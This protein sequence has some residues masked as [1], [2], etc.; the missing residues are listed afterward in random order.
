MPK[1]R[2]KLKDYIESK[3]LYFCK[4]CSGSN[5]IHRLTRA[6]KLA[7]TMATHIKVK[8]KVEG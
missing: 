3:L 7:K 2:M 6:R 4:S 5:D 1:P 8:W